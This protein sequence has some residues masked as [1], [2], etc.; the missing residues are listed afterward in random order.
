MMLIETI[1]KNKVYKF[2][3][4]IFL[5][6][7]IFNQVILYGVINYLYNNLSE[8]YENYN[9]GNNPGEMIFKDN[10]ILPE[11]C[12]HFSHYSSDKGCPCI[13]IEQQNYLRMRGLNRNK[14]SYNHSPGLKNIYF[15]PTN[16]LK[17]LKDEKFLKHNTYINKSP[18]E[19]SAERKN[20]VYSLL[21]IQER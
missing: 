9:L 16:T 10:K 20:E 21:N 7:I 4:Y 14:S 13:T 12:S 8:N 1:R 6:L 15:S 19:M 3:F 18:V 2:L 11:C 17:G 5:L